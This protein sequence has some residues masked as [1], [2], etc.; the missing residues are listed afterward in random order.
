MWRVRPCSLGLTA[1]TNKKVSRIKY[2]TVGNMS[3][4]DV[5][6]AVADLRR[7]QS[8]LRQEI[9][10]DVHS[11]LQAMQQNNQQLSSNLEK[12]YAAI[13]K[14][15]I[16]PLQQRLNQLRVT[17]KTIRDIT[18]KLQ[19]ISNN[20]TPQIPSSSGH[21]PGTE[22]E[23]NNE[24]DA[25]KM[26]TTETAMVLYV[27]QPPLPQEVEE[28][29]AELRRRQS[30]LHEEIN[31]DVRSALQAISQ[32]IQKLSSNLEKFYAAK[33]KSDIEPLQQRLDQLRVTKKTIRDV[34]EKLQ[35]I[36]KMTTTIP[37]SSSPS[38]VTI[39]AL[40]S[41][42]HNNEKDAEKKTM[43]QTAMTFK[44]Q[45]A[46][47]LLPVLQPPQEAEKEIRVAEIASDDDT[48]DDSAC[49]LELSKGS[50]VVLCSLCNAIVRKVEEEG[51]EACKAKRLMSTRCANAFCNKNVPRDRYVAKIV[52]YS[53]VLSHILSLAHICPFTNHH[54]F[55]FMILLGIAAMIVSD[56][57]GTITI[58]CTN[59]NNNNNNNNNTD[60][61]NNNNN[62]N[63]VTQNWTTV[64]AGTM[65]DPTLLLMMWSSLRWQR[66][67]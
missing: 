1:G 13:E 38:P 66:Q 33:E 43:M 4:E 41:P 49:G 9:H 58:D 46:P 28:A 26:T 50:G 63:R 53:Y 20:S 23:R 47:S 12:F 34:T 55:T 61:N 11:A 7:R 62:N 59:N 56:A 48:K 64:I 37:T 57:V 54:N 8:A 31:R 32:N 35:N 67:G 14:S 21:S 15:D 17:K 24:E 27:H 44:D 42:E 10:R 36:R 6:E 30:R 22:S 39:T 3:V 5:E 51:S 65:M 25:A 2:R 18:E 52:I 40:T 45:Q 60:N 16:E 29:V 19:N